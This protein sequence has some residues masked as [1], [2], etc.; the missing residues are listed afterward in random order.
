MPNNFE[1]YDIGYETEDNYNN[2]LN[3]EESDE[4][5]KAYAELIDC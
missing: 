1:T 4:L 2:Y 5:M 3:S